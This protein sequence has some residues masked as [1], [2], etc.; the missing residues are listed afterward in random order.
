MQ[1]YKGARGGVGPNEESPN[2]TSTVI[3]AEQQILISRCS[4]KKAGFYSQ[5]L[6]LQEV[7]SN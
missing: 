2:V 5:K 7:M 4:N 1:N 6:S 3:I